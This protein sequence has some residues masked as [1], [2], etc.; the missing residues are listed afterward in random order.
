MKRIIT[1]HYELRTKDA[2]GMVELQERL[3][4]VNLLSSAQR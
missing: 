1:V 3:K 4:M 2:N